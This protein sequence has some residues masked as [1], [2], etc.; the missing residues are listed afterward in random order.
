MEAG[1]EKVYQLVEKARLADPVDTAALD[2]IRDTYGYDLYKQA[3][4]AVLV[5]LEDYQFVMEKYVVGGSFGDIQLLEDDGVRFVLDCNGRKAVVEF[6][7]EWS[8]YVYTVN[9]KGPFAH[10]SYE[11]IQGDIAEVLEME[12]RALAAKL[13]EFYKGYDFYDYMDNMEIGQTDE[14]VIAALAE[15][16]T[17]VKMAETILDSLLEFKEEGPIDEKEDALLLDGLI[18]EMKDIVSGEGKPLGV[19]L[20]E[21]KLSFDEL[22]LCIGLKDGWTGHSNN[23]YQNLLS[24]DGFGKGVDEVVAEAAQR[25][26]VAAR[27]KIQIDILQVKQGVAYRDFRFEPLRRVKG[28]VDGVHVEN[29]NHVYSYSEMQFGSLEDTDGVMA[30]LEDVYAKFNIRHPEDFKGHSLSVSDV[31]VLTK[32]GMSKAFYC[33]SIGFKELPD[34]FIKGITAGKDSVGFGKE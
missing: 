9:G 2:E 14:D 16:L 6:D 21:G 12:R 34:A 28:G 27:E 22:G 8:E 5:K 3:L 17:D 31:V 13:V 4:D 19:V 23:F 11:F 24:D 1:Y 30:L 26:E 10:A 20:N 15:E 7:P 29:Y 32:C 25:S 18:Q 33:D